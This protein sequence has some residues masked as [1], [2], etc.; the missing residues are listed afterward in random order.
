M[1]AIKHVKQGFFSA[2]SPNVTHSENQGTAGSQNLHPSKL[3]SATLV[4]ALELSHF[5]YHIAPGVPG[6]VWPGPIN[7]FP[8]SP[9]YG[10]GRN[11]N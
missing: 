10:S 11:T 7:T 1:G 3:T 4:Q 6:M 5:H 9:R 8:E 2:H